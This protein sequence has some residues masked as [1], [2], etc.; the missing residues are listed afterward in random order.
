[1]INS[2]KMSLVG[3]AVST[4][5]ESAGDSLVD[6]GAQHFCEALIL[7]CDPTKQTRKSPNA[8]PGLERSRVPQRQRFFQHIGRKEI[9]GDRRTQTEDRQRAGVQP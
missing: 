4:C 6:C 5:P 8:F 3:H 1:M 2:L 9:S 7:T